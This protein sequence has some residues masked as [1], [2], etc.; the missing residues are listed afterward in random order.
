MF[1]LIT[2]LALTCATLQA[3]AV[4]ASTA[5]DQGQSAAP[6][7]PVNPVIEW[8]RTLLVV[9]RTPG[10]QPATIHSTRNF[11]ILHAAI[12]D[13]VDNIEGGFTPY[14]VRLPDVSHRA[15]QPAAADQA[16]HDVLVNLYPAFKSMLDAELQA[17]L[18]LIP[19]GNDKADGIAVGQAVAAQILAVRSN[20]GSGVTPP[21]YM[22]VD[23][24]GFYQPTPPD[25]TPA[26]FTQWPDVVPF[27]ITRADEFLPAPPPKLDSLEYTHV[28]NLTKSLGEAGSNTRTPKETQI[29]LFW[30]GKIQNY[31]NE[32]TQTA[33]LR[34]GLNLA[35]SAR[36]FALLNIS[37]ADSTIAFYQAKYFYQV[38]RPVTAIQ[39]AGTDGNPDTTANPAWL[40]LSTKTAPDPS[41]PG[42]HSAI[43][44]AG[45][46]VLKFYFGSD[47][48]TFDAT[49]ETV[50]GAKRHFT[51]FSAAAQE[52]GLSRIYA[53]QHFLSDH[54]SGKQL[55]H[56]VANSV[57]ETILLPQ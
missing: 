4:P 19:D 42:A 57:R 9:V 10:A 7:Q 26:D 11:A 46:E 49:S 12:Y 22:P 31:W 24:P 43:S 2:M 51:S 34:H 30:N 35:K 5:A 18:A 8:N 20:D 48:F 16:A 21:P 47:Q 32:I 40:P 17:D 52:A 27:A 36:L 38:W 53:G 28:F 44:A 54:T 41:Y 6:G 13:A 37:L 15:S 56:E 50:P 25:F 45:A 39:E 3:Q 1:K 29:G 14:L 55:G 23:K 33:A